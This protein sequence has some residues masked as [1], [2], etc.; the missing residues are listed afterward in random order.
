MQA[1]QDWGENTRFEY[2]TQILA[3][4]F[5]I[6]TDNWRFIITLCPE[7]EK[8][9]V[10]WDKFSLENWNYILESLPHLA[11][12]CPCLD[13]FSP[14]QWCNLLKKHPELAHKCH[15][16]KDFSQEIWIELCWHQ[17]QFMEQASAFLCKGNLGIVVNEKLQAPRELR[18]ILR[19]KM[20]Y[21]NR[22]WENDWQKLTENDFDKLLGQVNFVWSIDKRN[23]EFAEYRKQ[24]LEIKRYFTLQNSNASR[25]KQC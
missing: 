10:P 12:K 1:L 8:L 24:L 23:S 22:F 25:Q 2:I 15:C 13:K 7:T 21:L 20:Y 16:Y 11:D 5:T 17:M 4:G 9:P 6:D 3:D 19:Q 18:R 14:E